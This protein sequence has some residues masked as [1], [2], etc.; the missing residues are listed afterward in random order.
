MNNAKQNNEHEEEQGYENWMQEV[1]RPAETQRRALAREEARL[2]APPDMQ[3][4]EYFNYRQEQR[5]KEQE[6]RAKAQQEQQEQEKAQHAT[7]PVKLYAKTLGMGRA[8]L[9]GPVFSSAWGARKEGHIKLKYLSPQGVQV[10]YS[11]P[12]LRRDDGRVLEFL[13]HAVRRD[14]VGRSIHISPIEFAKEMGWKVANTT[15]AV[16]QL[17][18]CLQRMQNAMLQLGKPGALVRAQLIAELRED[19]NDWTVWLNPS[20]VQL[21]SDGCTFIPLDERRKAGDGLEGWLVGYLRANDDETKF[22]LGELMIAAGRGDGA[23]RDFGQ[24]MRVAMDAVQAAGTVKDFGFS[25]GTMSV[26]R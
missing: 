2:A 20:I 24:A 11:G 1:A 9:C 13:V 6:Q 15:R 25:R 3:E 22:D 8:V 4:L 21:F 26:V 18:E 12:E 17:R 5:A 7:L 14:A 19:G 23:L 10:E 16:T